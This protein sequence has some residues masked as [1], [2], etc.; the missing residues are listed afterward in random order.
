MTWILCRPN[1]LGAYFPD[2]EFVDKDEKLRAE[3]E[4]TVDVPEGVHPEGAFREFR[5]E[6]APTTSRLTEPVEAFRRPEKLVLNASAKDFADIMLLGNGLLA[7]S[8]PVKETIEQFEPD[9]HQF[10]PMALLRKNG[11]PVNDKSYSVLLVLQSQ[12]GF[13]PDQSA[14]GSARTTYSYS[15]HWHIAD[16]KKTLIEGIAIDADAVKGAHLWWEE[17]I[18]TGC[19]F[20]SDEL[21]EALL[22]TGLKLWPKFYRCTEV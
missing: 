22:A 4:R 16:H 18:L 11:K 5:I 8:A 17:C 3:F 19:F 7:V 9:V 20:L 1:G 13:R 10:W 6:K 14:E 12:N 2:A 21:A 15:E